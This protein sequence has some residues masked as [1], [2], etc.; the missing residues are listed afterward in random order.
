MENFDW[1]ARV[2]AK[3]S[4]L[5]LVL[6]VFVFAILISSAIEVSVNGGSQV[7]QVV[8]SVPPP[9][10]SGSSSPATTTATSTGSTPPVASSTAPFI[11][12]VSPNGGEVWSAGSTWPIKWFSGGVSKVTVQVVNTAVPKKV[13]FPILSETVPAIPGVYHWRIPETASTSS[14]YK[15]VITAADQSPVGLSDESDRP[16]TITGPNSGGSNSRKPVSISILNSTTV[17]P[18]AYL[19]DVLTR[20]PVDLGSFSLKASAGGGRINIDRLV[21]QLKITGQGGMAAD[22]SNV[23]IFT[24][25]DLPSSKSAALATVNPVDSTIVLDQTSLAAEAG[26]TMTYR[27]V[28]NL[29]PK[30]QNGQTI[31]LSASPKRDGWH[32]QVFPSGNPVTFGPE[33]VF[34]SRIG[35]F[36]NGFFVP[37]LGEIS[38]N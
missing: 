8:S 4:S 30:F 26:A 7:A 38:C 24:D 36:K 13:D 25:K 27:I 21:F 19:V 32:G 16:F 22:I 11:T 29:G 3:T 33:T 9:N 18:R 35:L 5:L 14:T 12:V 28:A 10:S 23:S 6:A 17:P 34:L 20:R 37:G 31:Q 2:S 1:N 15:A